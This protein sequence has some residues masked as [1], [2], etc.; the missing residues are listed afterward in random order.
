MP[1]QVMGVTEASIPFST[2]LPTSIGTGENIEWTP[3]EADSQTCLPGASSMS[4][5][6]TASQVAGKLEMQLAPSPTC[7]IKILAHVSCFFVGRKG[8][9]L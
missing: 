6:V 7:Y 9:T 2:F 4:L 1:D 3:K 5:A 8:L